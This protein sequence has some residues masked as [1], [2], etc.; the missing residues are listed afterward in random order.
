MMLKYL[1]C[2]AELSSNNTIHVSS[3]NMHVIWLQAFF[4]TYGEQA[5]AQ[6]GQ[7]DLQNVFSSLN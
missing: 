3:E 6:F 2:T 5:S 1:L 4:P 7:H